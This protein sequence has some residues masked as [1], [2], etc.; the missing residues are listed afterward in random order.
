MAILITMALTI[1]KWLSSHSGIGNLY[2]CIIICKPFRTQIPIIICYLYMQTI[3]KTTVRSVWDG[4]FCASGTTL[5]LDAFSY[6][7]QRRCS[8]HEVWNNCEA[9]FLVIMCY[10]THRFFSETIVKV[11]I[12]SNSERSE[13]VCV[14]AVILYCAN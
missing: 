1:I 10:L 2:K 7:R 12:T 13:K 11:K 4:C 9:L 6:A 5:W 8:G 3:W 14:F